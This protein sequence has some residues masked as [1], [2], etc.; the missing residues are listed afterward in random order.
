M[1]PGDQKHIMD[2]SLF[3]SGE[4]ILKIW[5]DGVYHFKE[6]YIK[7]HVEHLIYPNKVCLIIFHYYNYVKLTYSWLI[8]I[9]ICSFIPIFILYNLFLDIIYEFFYYLQATVT[10]GD[11]ICFLMPVKFNEE[12][13]CEWLS[14]NSKTLA[15]DSSSGFSVAMAPAEVF[16][17]YSNNKFT[18]STS[19][20]IL[21]IKTVCNNYFI[22]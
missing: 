13:S 5:D 21:P 17:T 12:N 15:V 3:E 16:V 14:H 6:D 20:N 7:F 4:V 19:I 8:L 10:V 22:F 9:F 18:T 11:V 2:V 1:T